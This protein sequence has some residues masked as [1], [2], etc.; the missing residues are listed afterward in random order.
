MSKIGIITKF[1]IVRQLKKPSFW[2]AL[3]L[4]PLLLGGIMGISALSNYR[5][6]ETMDKRASSGDETAKISVIDHAGIVNESVLP[7]GVLT[8]ITKEEGI[9][10]IKK[11]E[12]D[13][14]YVIEK[15]FVETK[16]IE[17][18][19]GKKDDGSLS[20]FG[21][22]SSGNI[23]SILIAS[24]ATRVNPA[25]VIILSNSIEYSKTILDSNGEEVN[26]LGK[27]IVPIAVLVIFYIL[28]CVFGN[29]MLMAVVE[30]KENRISEM[31]L[32]SATAKQLIVGK[33]LALITLGFLQMLV[34]SIPVI[35]AAIIYRDNAMVSGILGIIEL[36]PATIIGNVLLLIA[37][38]MLF[39]GAST[40]VGS[41]MP[42]ARD[43]SQYI[44]VVV[45]G[46][47][48][49]LMFFGEMVSPEP[50]MMVYFLS[51][52]PLSSPI[53]MMLRNAFGLLPWYEF[54]FGIVEIGVCSLIVIY[55]ASKSFQK[56]AINFSMIK[57]P[58][59]ARRRK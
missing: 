26:L 33:I 23:S 11:G 56:N 21:S 39:T 46:M 28:I 48:L 52:F 2:I 13:E 44:G 4:I 57:L 36:N 17:S 14:L 45:V 12:L 40:F 29:R 20:L 41:L 31:I 19:V 37:S 47:V 8:D 50:S 32:T 38:Y 30:E 55:F 54:I 22:M 3:L 42:T 43:A 53:A 5:M 15:D 24:A 51:Y 59:G 35:I 6:E 7:Q 10:L 18:F 34:F 27:A 58:F 25:D 49:P 1:E 9:D 16:K